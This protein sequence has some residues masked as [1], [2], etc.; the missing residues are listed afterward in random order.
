MLFLGAEFEGVLGPGVRFS[1][2]HRRHLHRH[3]GWCHRCN[4]YDGEVNCVDDGRRCGDGEEEGGVVRRRGEKE[5]RE[6]EGGREREREE[7]EG[8]GV[9]WLR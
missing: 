8:F 4:G 2:G 6:R 7:E 1:G 9:I 3:G 5:G